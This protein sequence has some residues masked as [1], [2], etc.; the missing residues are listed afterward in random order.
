MIKLDN[1]ALRHALNVVEMMNTPRQ[2][3]NLYVEDETHQ[4][5]IYIKYGTIHTNGEHEQAIAT[6][7][8]YVERGQVKSHKI[9][10]P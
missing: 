10:H 2:W 8:F 5:L 3:A 9:V 7:Y 6:R 1:L 4:T